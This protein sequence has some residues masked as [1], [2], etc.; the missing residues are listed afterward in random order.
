MKLIVLAA[1]QGTRLRPYTND[2]PKCLVQVQGKS[3]L[4]YQLEACDRLGIHDQIVIAGYKQEKITRKGLKKIIN[5]RYH[6]TNMVSSLFCA[7]DFFD[8]DIF[9]TYGEII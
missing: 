6:Q 8:D 5:T 3:I 7:S 4:D 9:I 2:K 1:G